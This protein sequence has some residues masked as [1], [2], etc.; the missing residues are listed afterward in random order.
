MSFLDFR[1]RL[2]RGGEGRTTPALGAVANAVCDALPD[3]GVEH[4][5]LP[6]TAERVWQVIRDARLVSKS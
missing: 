5:E 1:T 4:I 2:A 6:A 3:L